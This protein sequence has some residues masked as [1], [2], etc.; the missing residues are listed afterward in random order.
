MSELSTHT[1][2]ISIT[3]GF[4]NAI[5]EMSII[6]EEVWTVR[7]NSRR[8]LLHVSAQTCHLSSTTILTMLNQVTTFLY[9]VAFQYREIK[10]CLSEMDYPFIV[11]LLPFAMIWFSSPRGF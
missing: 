5:R 6:K 7:G 2:G 1:R 3:S 4:L 9:F 10:E 11:E 8:P